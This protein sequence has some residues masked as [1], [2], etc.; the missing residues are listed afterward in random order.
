MQ[1][2]RLSLRQKLFLLFVIPA[3]AL[4]Y[5]STYFIQSKYTIVKQNKHYTQAVNSSR[6][7]M[8]A[9]HNINGNLLFF[10]KVKK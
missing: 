3:I 5:F 7:I 4:I 10:K 6:N 1:S 8:Q 9:I 2:N